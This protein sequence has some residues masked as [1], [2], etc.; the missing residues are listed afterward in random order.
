MRER[1]K[2][3]EEVERLMTELITK[4][5]Q[6]RAETLNLHD[7]INTL[8]SKI[9]SAIS[10]KKS[11]SDQNELSMRELVSDISHEKNYFTKSVLYSQ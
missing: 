10:E 3:T 7:R 9:T 2:M 11:V 8:E 5:E 1:K 4:K 6:H